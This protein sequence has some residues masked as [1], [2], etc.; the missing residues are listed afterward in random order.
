[1][2]GEIIAT[3]RSQSEDLAE[4]RQAQR[5]S[6]AERRRENEELR[7]AQ[8]A[9][10]DRIEVMRVDFEKRHTENTKRLDALY[11]RWRDLGRILAWA[12]GAASLIGGCVWVLVNP[13]Y[14]ALIGSLAPRLL[15]H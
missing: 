11:D 2:L 13:L 7:V 8:K 14:D 3:N 12:W 10:A 4:V 1:M 5:D 6:A 9:L 15:G